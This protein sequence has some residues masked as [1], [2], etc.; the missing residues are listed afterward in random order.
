MD[1]STSDGITELFRIYWTFS[2]D[3]TVPNRLVDAS[4]SGEPVHYRVV[5][6]DTGTKHEFDGVW[7]FSSSSYLSLSMFDR[8]YSSYGLSYN[9]GAWGA[10]SG[11]INGHAYLTPSNNFWGIGNFMGS[12]W[13]DCTKVYLNGFQDSRYGYMAKTFMYYNVSIVPV[14]EPTAPPTVAATTA[15][16]VPD[17]TQAP[18]ATPTTSSPTTAYNPT[19]GDGRYL[20]AVVG[21]DACAED[22]FFG[23]QAITKAGSADGQHVNFFSTHTAAKDVPH[24][25]WLQIV[26]RDGENE[27]FRI[28]WT[29][30]S[31][32]TLRD[33]F[34]TAVQYSEYVQY[35]VVV[36]DSG[37]EFT[38]SGY[39]YFSTTSRITSNT[40][41]AGVTSCCFSANA[42]AW[43][44]GSNYISGDL[45]WGMGSYNF[46][47]V[48][49]F[50]TQESASCSL[51]YHEGTSENI[52]SAMKAYMYYSTCDF[53][54]RT[55]A[56]T[57]K[58]TMAPALNFKFYVKQVNCTSGLLW[59]PILLET[60]HRSPVKGLLDVT[61]IVRFF[62]ISMSC[63]CP[64][65]KMAGIDYATYVTIAEQFNALFALTVQQNVLGVAPGDVQNVTATE[66]TVSRRLSISSTVSALVYGTLAT[67]AVEVSYT[68]CNHNADASLVNIRR[69]LEYAIVNG[70]FDNAL[71]Q[72][73]MMSG[74]AAMTILH[75]ATLDT[76]VPSE[77]QDNGGGD[78]SAHGE[79][80]AAA[81]G[82]VLS[83]IFTKTVLIGLGA[84]GGGFLLLILF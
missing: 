60:L 13:S 79:E 33:R 41:D 11:T 27:I 29:F 61:K 54:D 43:G 35:R 15:P 75:S 6:A 51:V 3:K 45:V 8:T 70:I 46:W 22:L 66:T 42:G 56:P 12:D 67:D 34:T 39:W 69:N 76:T 9:D 21:G 50:D 59:L 18:S 44:G 38:Y 28:Y 71:R 57:L 30:M 74:V 68:I 52:G 7:W 36:K 47:G 73:A 2:T 4:N 80:D 31:P 48:G 72:A 16:P 37:Q 64:Q 5:E 19:N 65:Q 55:A 32:K 81:G 82:S 10:G 84:G 83:G 49:N 24:L 1:A 58:P 62:L 20:F 14:P 77:Y 26:T 23:P 63:R 25:Y 40:F 53:I 17:Y 78:G